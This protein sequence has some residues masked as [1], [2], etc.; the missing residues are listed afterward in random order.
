MKDL[1][2]QKTADLF[3]EELIITR[4]MCESIKAKSAK[5]GVFFQ[6]RFEGMTNAMRE[7][8][9]CPKDYLI[10]A[11][12]CLVDLCANS[13]R[14]AKDLIYQQREKHTDEQLVELMTGAR[15]P[16]VKNG[17][18]SMTFET[19]IEFDYRGVIVEEE[20]LVKLIALWVLTMC[21]GDID[22]AYFAVNDAYLRIVNRDNVVRFDRAA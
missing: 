6:L 21:K 2:D 22:K 7:S 1:K 19:I 13:E 20:S 3:P 12:E 14:K 17:I 11:A 16:V 5:E 9:L 4:L 8:D 10:G 15:K 18:I